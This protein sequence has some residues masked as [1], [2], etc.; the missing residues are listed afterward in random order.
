MDRKFYVDSH[1]NLQKAKE[2]QEI[3]VFE[4]KQNTGT[5]K[6]Q[7]PSWGGRTDLPA[8]R[9]GAAGMRPV[10]ELWRYY[11]LAREPTPTSEGTDTQERKPKNRTSVPPQG[12]RDVGAS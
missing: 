10:R 11:M 6:S 8:R 12:P 5:T 7:K 2:S 4:E 3:L 1:G 9:L